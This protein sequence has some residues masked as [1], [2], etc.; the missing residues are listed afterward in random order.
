[1][2]KILVALALLT[3]STVGLAVEIVRGG[4]SAVLADESIWIVDG[5]QVYM[6]FVGAIEPRI[7]GTLKNEGF[8]DGCVTVSSN[9][10]KS[11]QLEKE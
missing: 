3:V 9:Y 5:K 6:C 7:R 4:G 2:K 10:T 11:K 8:N 1:M